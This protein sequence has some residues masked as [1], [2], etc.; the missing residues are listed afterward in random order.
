VKVLVL[1]GRDVHGLLPFGECVDVMRGVL[2]ALARG[3]VHQPLRTVMRPPG[4]A[5]LMAQGAGTSAEF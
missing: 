3:E 4:A 5:G 1:S 2:G